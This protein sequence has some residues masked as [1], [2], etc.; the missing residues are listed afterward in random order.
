[1]ITTLLPPP[2][3]VSTLGAAQG[4]GGPPGP[5]GPSGGAGATYTAAEAVSGHA[6]LALDASGQAIYASANDAGH[7]LRIVG[8]SLSAAAAAASVGVQSAGYLEHAG[9]TWAPGALLDLG[10]A[11]AIVASPPVGAVFIQ[12]LG[13]AL[14]ATRVHLVPQPPVFIV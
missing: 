10:L 6:V 5:P 12:V 7:A 4:L 14:S 11:G 3:I 13:R 8:I 9:W 1:M 2:V